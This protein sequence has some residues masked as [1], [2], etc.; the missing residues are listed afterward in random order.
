[1]AKKFLSV[2]PLFYLVISLILSIVLRIPS[3]FDPY[4]YVDEGVY[5]T[6]GQ[7]IRKGLTLYRDLYDNKP[8]L[9]YFSAALTPNQFWWHLL[10]IIAALC[11]VYL[12]YRLAKLLLKNSRAVSVATVLFSLLWNLPFLEGHTV[13][14][15]HFFVPLGFL[16]L[17]LALRKNNHLFRDLIFSGILFG[18]GFLFKF[19]SF[20]DLL[21]LA[22]FWL[23]LRE[24]KLSLSYF[25]TTVKNLLLIGLGFSVPLVLSVVYFFFRGELIGYWEAAFTGNFD[26]AVRW[27]PVLPSFL[28]ILEAE[29]MKGRFIILVAL[30]AVL[31][32]LRKK[33]SP[34][35]LFI[36]VWLLFNLF[37]TLLSGRGYP[38]YLLTSVPAA[39]LFLGL[40]IFGLWRERG[41]ALGFTGLVIGSILAFHFYFYPSLSYYSNFISLV[42]GQ[43]SWSTYAQNNFGWTTGRNLEIADYI[44]QRTEATDRI[45]ILSDQPHLYAL[46]DRVPGV[47]YLFIFQMNDLHREEVVMRTLQENPPKM[48]VIFADEPRT[49]PGFNELLSLRYQ[50]STSIYN[51]MVY[52]LTD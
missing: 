31:F 30:L 40:F 49:L 42:R 18:L 1:M 19:H 4:W 43:E 34:A 45:F 3:L 38:H 5:L 8:P 21:S 48:I 17:L 7:I 33:F 26:Y 14:A 29:T 52:E 36:S 12:F 51:A 11:A 10:G 35:V 47:P 20:F 23:L 16:A 41:L 25:F 37:G 6:G 32:F 28:M 50:F 39:V 9:I 24:P 22:F 15:E 13:N 46:T 27:R 2:S 44:K